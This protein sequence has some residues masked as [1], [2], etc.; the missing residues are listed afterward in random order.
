MRSAKACKS[1]SCQKMNQKAKAIVDN[2]E[3]VNRLFLVKHNV[4]FD[5]A[6]SLEDHEALAYA[7]IFGQFEGNVWNWSTSQWDKD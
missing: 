2:G 7:I 1:I 6:M 3:I 5:V 4:P